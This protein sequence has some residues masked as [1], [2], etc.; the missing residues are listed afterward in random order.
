MKA[1]MTKLSHYC[2]LGDEEHSALEKLPV[3]ERTFEPGQEVIEKGEEPTE[4][5]IIKSGWAARYIT[6]KDGRTQV[7][8]F[9]LPGDFF[10][11]QVFVADASDHS[12]SAITTTTVLAVPGRAMVDIFRQNNCIGLAMWWATLQE[13]AILREHIVCNGRRDATERVA[14]LL[15][16]LNRRASI[17]GEGD[18]ISFRLP[19]SQALIADA[20]GLSYVHV[21]RVLK[22]LSNEG[23]ILREKEMVLIK[24]RKGLIDLCDFNADY[25]HLDAEPPQYRL[26][27]HIF[28][29]DQSASP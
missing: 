22:K 19:V 21:S 1:F 17:V 29:P 5:L 27:S 4:A 11:L 15:L 18:D 24:D 26:K 28:R 16:E 3:R 7:L 25:L 13:E 8:N 23:F 6:L 12:V 20:L 14:H 9:L 2:D 10:D